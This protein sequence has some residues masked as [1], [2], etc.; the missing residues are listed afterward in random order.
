MKV[1]GLERI[2][3][4]LIGIE[5]KQSKP[6]QAKEDFID[7]KTYLYMLILFSVNI[8]NGAASG[9]GSIIVQS[10]GVCYFSVQKCNAYY[11]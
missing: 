4:E 10:F 8:T 9:F 7:S 1:V 5:N 6:E 2:R 3:S 11:V